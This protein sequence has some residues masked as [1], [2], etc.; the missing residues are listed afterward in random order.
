MNNAG[1]NIRETALEVSEEHWDRI[2]S[3]NLKGVFFFA[4]AAG[5]IMSPGT[6]C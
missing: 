3:V 6:E 2:L 5:K 1:I 4:Q